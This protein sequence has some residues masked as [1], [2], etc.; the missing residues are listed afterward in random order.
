MRFDSGGHKQHGWGSQGLLRPAPSK[1]LLV[2][3][4]T[5]S[6]CRVQGHW[7]VSSIV[8]FTS[9][10]YLLFNKHEGRI[11]RAKQPKKSWDSIIKVNN[12]MGQNLVFEVQHEI[13]VET[14]NSVVMCQSGQTL[15][16][17]RFFN[18]IKCSLCWNYFKPELVCSMTSCKC[19]I[20]FKSQQ[21]FMSASRWL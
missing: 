4:S 12:I 19:H 16:P 11:S 13:Q 3:S 1:Q 10:Y 18:M 15:W 8:C 20:K 7:N 14:I 5:S 6:S 2:E 17:K 21:E 9:N